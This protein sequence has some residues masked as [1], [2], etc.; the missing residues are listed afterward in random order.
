MRRTTIPIPARRNTT[1]ASASSC[2]NSGGSQPT[3]PRARSTAGP[4]PEVMIGTAS[5][6]SCARCTRRASSS[7]RPMAWPILWATTWAR[8]VVAV[9][10]TTKMTAVQ[11]AMFSGGR[12]DCG[13][14]EDIAVDVGAH[15]TAHALYG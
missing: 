8:N 11:W 14:H 4:V 5:R 1:T 10:A 2:A 3:A 6:A 7:V 15:A 9:V 12:E 13:E